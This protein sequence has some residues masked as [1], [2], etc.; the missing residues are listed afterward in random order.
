MTAMLAHAAPDVDPA[1]AAFEILERLGARP[2]VP[3]FAFIAGLKDE[4]SDAV[5]KEA[6]EVVPGPRA[7]SDGGFAVTV[8]DEDT[9]EVDDALSC[10]ALDDGGIRVRV[11]IALVADFVAKGGAMDQ[12]AAARATTVYLPET[13]IRMLPDPVSTRA[14]SLIEGEDRPVLTTDVRLSADREMLDASIYPARIPLKRRLAYDQVYRIIASGASGDEPG[15]TV[16]RLNAAAIQLRQRRRT[17][18]AVLV[19]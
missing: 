16:A 1:E 7:I 15:V 2:R 17:A 18:G 4:F 9:I 3:R 12:E 13:T 5:M 19:Q 11:H 10:E 8:D 6:A 14:A